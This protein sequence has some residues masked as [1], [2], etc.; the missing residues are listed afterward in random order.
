MSS[1]A[2]PKK[3]KSL[4]KKSAASQTSPR[5]IYRRDML[6]KANATLPQV[7]TQLLSKHLPKALL[8]KLNVTKAC[9]MS[10]H[11]VDKHLRERLGDLVVQVPFAK[12]KGLCCVHIEQQTRS[13]FSAQRAL[14]YQTRFL[15]AV[16]KE[17]GGAQPIVV[18]TIVIFSTKLADTHASD[19]FA[20]L[21]EDTQNIAKECLGKIY[22]VQLGEYSQEQLNDG[23]MCGVLEIMLRHRRG[24]RMLPTLNK[25]WGPLSEIRQQPQGQEFV[26]ATLNYA[27]LAAQEGEKC[28]IIKLIGE[29]LGDYEE[30]NTMT[31]AAA[32][33]RE[34][35]EAR[36]EG[37]QEG[38]QEGLMEG[39]QEGELAGMEKAASGMLQ[40][41]IS[42]GVVK[43]ITHLSRQRILE[44]IGQLG[45]EKV[46]K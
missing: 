6:F 13:S 4:R 38:R 27:L 19:V 21:D 41:G 12:Q 46:S 32:L 36:I 34:A 22:P 14:E 3:P 10:A 45:P 7:Y 39:L 5:P 29:Y 31:V 28:D 8:Q 17:K 35:K 43:R 33:K 23:S 11:S 15:R 9:L 44:L 2:F 16:H 30:I 40:E 20:G 42:L 37:R 24:A 1:P 18:C 26:D 25:L